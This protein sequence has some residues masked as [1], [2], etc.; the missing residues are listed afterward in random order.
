MNAKS[1]LT[2]SWPLLNFHCND[3]GWPVIQCCAN[4]EVVDLFPNEDWIVYCSNKGCKNHTGERINQ[5]HEPDWLSE[6]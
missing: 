2:T 6:S 1:I 3:C 5:D 4:D